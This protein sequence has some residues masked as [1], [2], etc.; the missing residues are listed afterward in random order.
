LTLLR[1]LITVAAPPYPLITIHGV[2]ILEHDATVSRLR[3]F[4]DTQQYLAGSGTENGPKLKVLFAT[5]GM[6]QVL[7]KLLNE[8]EI[9]DNSRSSAG[10]GPGGTG[11]ERQK[12]GELDLSDG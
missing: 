10:R 2:E 3:S 6:S 5:S 9:C 4:V 7:S 8:D 11:K 1:D 12:L